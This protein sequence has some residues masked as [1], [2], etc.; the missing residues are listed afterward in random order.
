[1][2]DIK[3]CLVGPAAPALNTAP[4]KVVRR[5]RYFVVTCKNSRLLDVSQAKSIWASSQ[6]TSVLLNAA[7]QVCS[8]FQC[9]LVNSGQNK[10]LKSS[11]KL[12][13]PLQS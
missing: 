13:Q 10:I 7:L 3:C 5:C 8:L 1:M 9:F 2:D 11:T 4:Q 12:N 6:P